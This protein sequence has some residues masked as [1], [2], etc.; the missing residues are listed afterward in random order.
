MNFLNDTFTDTAGV[1]LTAH[2]GEIGATWTAHAFSLSVPDAIIMAGGR[3]RA[4]TT[5]NKLYYTS[6]VPDSA[7]Y[8][9]TVRVVATEA[10][11]SHTGA[12]ARVDP[13]A[14]T[15]YSLTSNGN[16]FALFKA[17]A[18]AF[19]QLGG[20]TATLAAGAAYDITLHP[21]GTAIRGKVQRVSDGL[22]LQTDGTWAAGEVFCINVTDN[23]ITAAGRAG[24]WVSGSGTDAS[25]KSIDVI[26]ASTAAAVGASA[27]TLTG[28]ASGTVG[29]ES[30]YF[31]VT[32]NGNYNGSVT[33]SAGSGGGTFTPGTLTWTGDANAKVFTYTPGTPGAKSISSTSNPALANPA[34]VAFTA[35]ATADFLVPAD[36]ARLWFNDNWTGVAGS[37][38]SATRIAPQPGAYF[39]TKITV[40]S[41][42]ASVKLVFDASILAGIATANY[43][44][45]QA[46]VDGVL[47]APVQLPATGTTVTVAANIAVG[48]HEVIVYHKGV[49]LADSNITRFDLTGSAAYV[50]KVGGIRVTTG[51]TVAAATIK[52][53]RAAFFGDSI[54]EGA[55]VDGSG[56]NIGDQNA[57]S[58]WAALIGRSNA[59][60]AE[61][62]IVG[63]SGNGYAATGWGCP[64]TFGS[65]GDS[66]RYVAQTG[67]GPTYQART[68]AGL[69]YVFIN[70]GTNDSANQS[71][72][73]TET[74]EEIRAAV[75]NTAVIF[76]IAPFPPDRGAQRTWTQAGFNAYVAAHPT[77]NRVC[78]INITSQDGYVQIA[79]LHPNATDTPV[80]VGFV[81]PRVLAFLN[82]LGS[83]TP[84]GVESVVITGPTSGGAIP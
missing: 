12:L 17:V 57:V 36:D 74:L 1:G 30:A 73:V 29:E 79:P 50:L 48:T 54:T 55:E 81:Q 14:I 35:N 33:P 80:I 45:V 78:F 44:Y 38:S 21:L 20:R 5:E 68:L 18:G 72:K 16:E 53:K 3:V 56:N 76:Q 25:G 60:N 82:S 63:W 22:W 2:I 84:S 58:N 10:G 61:Y 62:V 52:P 75:G 4:S 19:G 49:R 9:V 46:S 13:A 23:A 66:W 51:C 67:A 28:P 7:D 31:T 24:I 37:G 69:D 15:W 32:P 59:L 27:Y 77:D 83:G 8:S 11:G 42:G 26:T 64:L 39:K 6:G 47:Q 40:P 41:A 65:P 43:P 70:H 71:A 34:A